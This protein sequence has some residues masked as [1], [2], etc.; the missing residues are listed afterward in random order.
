MY[1]TSLSPMAY[2]WAGLKVLDPPGP[3]WHISELAQATSSVQS[4][5]GYIPQVFRRETHTE[6]LD[7]AVNHRPHHLF[8]NNGDRCLRE[9]ISRLWD[10]ESQKCTAATALSA[11]PGTHKSSDSIS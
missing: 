10:F 2:I 5:V 4:F 1:L 3:G 11:Q 7:A 9:V 8:A 6:L